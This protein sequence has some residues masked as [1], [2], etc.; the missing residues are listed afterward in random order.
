[1]LNETFSLSHSKPKASKDYSANNKDNGNKEWNNNSRK[2]AYSSSS[3]QNNS[4]NSSFDDDAQKK[5]GKAKAISSDQ[6]F[7]NDKPS[8]SFVFYL[9][10][11]FGDNFNLFLS[12]KVIQTPDVLK[13]RAALVRT[14]TLDVHQV[15]LNNLR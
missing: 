7:G 15:C 6:F 4:N 10:R 1:M 13:A 12:M 9:V 5:F 11:I 14:I 3:K 8:V 2:S